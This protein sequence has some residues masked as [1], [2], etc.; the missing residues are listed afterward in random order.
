MTPPG[1]SRPDRIFDKLQSEDLANEVRILWCE[2]AVCA[3]LAL[4]V[5]AYLIVG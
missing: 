2:V 1:P 3:S 4:I 5:A